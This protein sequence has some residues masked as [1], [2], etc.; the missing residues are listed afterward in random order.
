M[1]NQLNF[2]PSQVTGLIDKVEAVDVTQPHFN[3]ALNIARHGISI[4]KL[5][6]YYLGEKKPWG[7]SLINLKDM[8]KEQLSIFWFWTEKRH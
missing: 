2:L 8:F 4:G 3:K 1:P 7:K 5:Q 6:K